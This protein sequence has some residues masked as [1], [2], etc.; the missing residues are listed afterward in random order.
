MRSWSTYLIIWCSNLFEFAIYTVVKYR[1]WSPMICF[2]FGHNDVSR[3]SKTLRVWIAKFGSRRICHDFVAQL[4]FSCV[5]LSNGF[6]KA[7][8]VMLA[9]PVVVLVAV[10]MSTSSA[11]KSTHLSKRV[12]GVVP[13]VVVY[14]LFHCTFHAWAGWVSE[15]KY[16]L[17]AAA[18]GAFTSW[19][20]IS[21][22]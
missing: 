4:F 14:L 12:G 18:R 17:I 15:I 10:A 6:L 19:R 3:C 9:S 7:N 21:L 16:G 8:F 5:D 22:N 1:N 2:R 20:S 13:G 11:K